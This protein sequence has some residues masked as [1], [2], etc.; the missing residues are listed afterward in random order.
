MTRQGTAMP[1]TMR[2]VVLT[3][4]GPVTNLVVQDRPVPATR[5]GQGHGRRGAGDDAQAGPRSSPKAQG[6]AA[7]MT[8]GP[9]NVYDIEDIR[10]AH[11]DLEQGNVVGKLVG[12]TGR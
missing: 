10:R 6:A 11:E 8:L 9:V 4:P 1:E 5:P 12:I 7:Q 3:E 2:A